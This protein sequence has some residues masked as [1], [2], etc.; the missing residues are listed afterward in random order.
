VKQFLA[1]GLLMIGAS[2]IV[3]G[4]TMRETDEQA[5]P[6]CT[7]TLAQSPVMSGIKLG[8]TQDQILALFPGSSED[9]EL[10]ASLN[11]PANP[12]GETAFSINPGLYGS[13]SKFA[14]VTLIKFTLMDNHLSSFNV[15]YAGPQWAHVDEFIEKLAAATKLPGPNAWSPYVGMDTQLKTL[16]CKGF[17]I[18]LFAGGKNVHNINYV[19]LKDRAAQKIIK[20]RRAKAREKRNGW[21]GNNP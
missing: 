12:S 5:E 20:E 16:T 2:L 18:S 1:V 4:Q 17:V 8:M 9:S 6:A 14:G 13:K 10:R 15:S 3:S 7:M 21:W 19:D 11:R